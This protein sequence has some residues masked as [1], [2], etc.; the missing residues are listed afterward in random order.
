[1]EESKRNF[2]LSKFKRATDSMVQIN[3]SR[4]D[5]GYRD[6]YGTCRHYSDYTVEQ[7][8]KVIKDGSLADQITLSRAFFER[9]GFYK[10]ILLYY[11]TL[12]KWS[13]LL[14]PNPANGKSLS[15]QALSKRYY[16]ALQFVDGLSLEDWLTKVSLTVLRDGAYYGA[17]T[18]LTRN[19][20]VK[21]D[22]PA[23]FCRNYLQDVY[24]NNIVEFNVGY[25]DTIKD[26]NLKEDALNLYPKVISAHYRRF[27][28][29]KV[30]TPWVII[31]S[32]IGFC[33]N[34]FGTNRPLFLNVIPSTMQYD[35]AV[36]TERKR[37][38]NE[39][40]K[41]LVQKIPHNNQN[42]LLFEP[43]EAVEMHRG[44]VDMMKNN[45]DVAVLTTYADVDAIVSKT[46]SDSV[47]DTVTKM[48]N[49]IYYQASVSPQI[50]APTGTKS[51]D[52]SIKND[53]ALMMALANQY[54]RF[55]DFVVGSL[56]SNSNISFSFKFL[57]VSYYTESE[58]ITDAFKLAQSGYS[59]LLPCVAAGIGQGELSGLKE[60]END[61]LK[62]DEKLIPLASAY[63]QSATSGEAGRPELKQSE[64]D[65]RTIANEVSLDRQ[66][67]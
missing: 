45:D 43:D 49:N 56:Y 42:E 9:D 58:Y 26:R 35:E 55:I 12:L 67:E 24:G 48:V 7:A 30:R 32:D 57:P 37:A 31:P 19:E 65:E 3:N 23:A 61:V 54:A 64:K 52:V 1:M 2:D 51:V 47:S 36:D 50:F 29:G 14:I 44:A 18:Q 17:I 4:Y 25:F 60:L 6:S 34:F 62:L 28:K 20:F 16:A 41:I 40:R 8:K 22:L 46:T 66:E 38:D 33:F 59:Y 10:R 11:A 53:I 21:I 5:N 63:T 39:L 13:Y 15:N 27:S